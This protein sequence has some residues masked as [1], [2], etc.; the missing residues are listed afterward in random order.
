[1]LSSFL[2]AILPVHDDGRAPTPSAKVE[3]EQSNIST[4]QYTFT[5]FRGAICLTSADVR[6]K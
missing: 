5:A 4:T 1:M 3:N 6:V 2:K